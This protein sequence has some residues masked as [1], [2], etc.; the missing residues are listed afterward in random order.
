[1]K[2][3]SFGKPVLSAVKRLRAGVVPYI[4]V[5]TFGFEDA[6]RKGKGWKKNGWG[7]APPAAANYR[8]HG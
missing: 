1:M 5:H 3:I 7:H 4:S 2:I 6:N 8:L